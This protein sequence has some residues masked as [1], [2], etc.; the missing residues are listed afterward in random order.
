MKQYHGKMWN[1]QQSLAFY[2]IYQGS[3]IGL[4]SW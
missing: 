1:S 3:K 2:F 4:T